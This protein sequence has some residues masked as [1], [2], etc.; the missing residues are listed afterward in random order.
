MEYQTRDKHNYT[1]YATYAAHG[2]EIFFIKSYSLY[3][4]L[5]ISSAMTSMKEM[6]RTQSWKVY[7]S[8][9]YMH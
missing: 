4:I 8:C 9:S 2:G 5:F 6:K 1:L 7:F 3:S